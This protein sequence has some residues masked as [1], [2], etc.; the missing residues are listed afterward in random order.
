MK[1]RYII[2]ILAI[3]IIS[4]SF[5]AY[6]NLN[7]KEINANNNIAIY[8]QDENNTS[9]YILSDLSTLPDDNYVFNA[10][11]TNSECNNVTFTY[12]E[13]NKKVSV[14]S[15][16]SIECNM[17]FDIVPCS[18]SIGE[19]TYFNYKNSA[20]KYTTVCN[21]NYKIELWGAEGNYYNSGINSTKI[22]KGAYT[23][24]IINLNKNIDLYI[25]TGEHNHDSNYYASMFNSGSIAAGKTAP[26]FPHYSSSGGGATDVRYFKN[27]NPTANDLEW[28]SSIGLNSRIMVAGAGGGNVYNADNNYSLGG[29]AGGLISYNGEYDGTLVN[30]DVSSCITYGSN[31]TSSG[32]PMGTFSCSGHTKGTYGVSGYGCTTNIGSYYVLGGSGG[33]G[34]YG[35]S[36]GG[37]NSGT[38]GG[39]GAGGSS[40]ISGHTGCVAIK[41]GSTS[42]PR[43][44]KKSGCTTGTTDRSCSIHYSD[45]EFIEGTTKMIDGAG[46][47]WTNVKGSTYERMPAAGTDKS[48]YYASGVGHTG[49]GYARITYCGNSTNC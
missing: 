17:Y 7:K 5:F 31:Q 49:S 4:I 12:D 43:Q 23:S 22:G 20:Q 33:G 26:S 48:A 30:R 21:G 10:T 34:Y 40:F 1:K 15:N 16:K 8:L 3:L 45:L 18:L 41:E 6:N 46:Y 25:Y 38:C 44:V 39:A 32:E 2:S 11:K 27:I 42:E 37:H 9:N 47:P 28:N 35:G 13:T 19:T 24:G 14:N 29:N 36:G